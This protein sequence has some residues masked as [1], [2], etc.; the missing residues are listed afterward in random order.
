MPTCRHCGVPFDGAYRE[1]YCGNECRFLSR[2]NKTESGCWT[3]TGAKT[4]AGYGAMNIRGTVS[5]A[6]RMAHELFKGPIGESLFVCHTCDN[7]SCVNPDHLFTGTPADN[8]ADMADKGRAA[9][10]R[11][12]MPPEVVAKIV[13]T[14]KRNNWKPSEAQIQASISARAKKML[15]PEWVEATYSKMRGANN[16][17]FGK[18]MSAEMRA[19][20]EEVHW[21]KLRG[22]KR[23][24]MSE[25]TKAKISAAHQR[26]KD[27]QCIGS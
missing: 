13:E 12:K 26:R 27:Q 3:W 20:L 5:L 8:S 9:W 4:A 1:R 16:H 15:D 22:K 7:P 11:R 10:A 6:H 24:P 25:E 14:R 19:K 2:V 17:N 18:T 23:G 21:S